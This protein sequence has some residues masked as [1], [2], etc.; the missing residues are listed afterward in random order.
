MA[1]FSLVLN[2]TG[3]LCMFLFGMK[4]MSDGIQ[5][6][7]GDRMR[8]ILHYMTY[9]RFV[10]MLTGFVV[11]ALV[12]SSSAVT[13][14][15][16]S[17]VNTGLLSLVQSIGVI[18]GTNVG[19]TITAWI[20]SIVG[21]KVEISNFALPA[22]GIGFI[23]GV[24]K[25]KYKSTGTMIMGFGFLFMGLHYLTHEMSSIQEVINFDTIGMFRDLGFTAILIGVLVGI[26]MTILVNSSSASIAIIMTMAFNDIV[27]FEM[28]AGMVLGANVGTTI[29]AFLAGLAGNTAAKRAAAVHILFNVVGIMWA[30]PLL[31]QI[32]HVIGLIIPGDPREVL[33]S[34][35]GL[36]IGN[37]AI[38]V[39]LAALQ[40]TIK[41]INSLLFLPLV[42]QFAWF[43]SFLIRDKPSSYDQGHYRFAYISSSRL[44]SPELNI[45]R[46]E[47]EIRDM[48]G[49]TASMYGR[50][51]RFI[52]ELKGMEDPVA[53]AAG[54]CEELK[55]KEEYTDE[56]REALTS[57]L[58]DC[59][60]SQLSSHSRRRVSQFLRVINYLEEM[61]DDC[62]IIS[63]TLQKSIAKNRLFSDREM[64]E[65]VPYLNLV[66]EFLDLVKGELLGQRISPALTQ[67]TK[68][69]ETRINKSRKKLQ[70]LSRK[71]IRAGKDIKTELFFIDLVRR[72][73]RLGDYCYDISST[74]GKIQEPQRSGA[75]RPALP[76]TSPRVG[77]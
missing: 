15:I 59:S 41:I 76:R 7:A 53:S 31:L 56:M 48:A 43:V 65:L 12:Q 44:D 38:P 32:L 57:F 73:E 63:L 5:Q 54:L 68:D 34:A 36:R 26:G 18:L 6:S 42:P 66:E 51:N 71:R 61:S 39:H 13:V 19:T 22:V 49:L 60:R 14:I 72:I 45:F 20:V 30:L 67:R 3:G 47:K 16:I 29:N 52:Q 70:K 1:I 69:L 25:W 9:N 21:F 28:A 74:L 8:K 4:I 77:S 62:Y 23:T 10:G 46:V 33:F 24:I 75:P 40:T 35:G 17:L 27:T 11:T 55:H 58:M 37:S 64:E 50:F 2:L